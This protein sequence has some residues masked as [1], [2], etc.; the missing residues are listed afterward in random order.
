[1]VS[2]LQQYWYLVPIVVLVA[3]QFIRAANRH[4]QA[5]KKG[6]EPE[7]KPEPQQP[8]ADAEPEPPAVELPAAEVEVLP[9]DDPT[10]IAPEANTL[11]TRLH[12]LESAYAPFGASSAHPRELAEHPQFKEAVDLLEDRFVPMSTVLQYA[13]GANWGLACAALAAMPGRFDADESIDEVV[14]HFD[15][16]APWAMHFAL[17]YFCAADS[18]PPVGA[19]VVGARDWWPSHPI[20]PLLFR[21][22][23]VRRAGFGD[24]AEFGSRL[25]TPGAAATAVI[26]AFLAR[27]DHPLARALIEKL[28]STVRGHI[29][30]AFL[31]S[32]G[33]FWAEQK[34]PEIPDRAGQLDKSARNRAIDAD[35]GAGALAAGER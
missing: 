13:L 22:Y 29:D 34:Q 3:A 28:D 18:R 21:D 35:A 24:A 7:P 31:M 17:E 9:P 16:L 30:R 1:M 8:A 23:F 15:K 33:R 6:P 11:T 12:M 2:T 5:A 10:L 25:T 19:P 32:F 27:I 26:R 20:L 14:A 4:R